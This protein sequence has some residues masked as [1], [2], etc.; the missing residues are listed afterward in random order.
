MGEHRCAC[1]QEA[2][3][4][5]PTEHAVVPLITFR[6]Q[7][8]NCGLEQ[9]C[10]AER[11]AQPDREDTLPADSDRMAR[12]QGVRRGFGDYDADPLLCRL[13]LARVQENERVMHECKDRRRPVV[14]T[15]SFLDSLSRRLDRLVWV[16]QHPQAARLDVQSTHTGSVN[17]RIRIKL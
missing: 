10:A 2:F 16:A 4:E 14:E 5:F 1:L 9:F 11:F 3:C 15:F 13:P 6:A 12:R 8:C 17:E 7:P